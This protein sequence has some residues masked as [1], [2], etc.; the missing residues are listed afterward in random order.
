MR[1]SVRCSIFESARHGSEGFL[2]DSNRK[3]HEDVKVDTLTYEG[4]GL[5][6]LEVINKIW[7]GFQNPNWFP[8]RYSFVFIF[9]LIYIAY[10]QSAHQS[11]LTLQELL[12]GA[13][14]SV[15]ISIYLM[16]QDFDYL[17][18]YKILHVQ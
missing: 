3:Q 15:L 17:S 8:Y 18:S 2:L 14:L 12:H 10:R 4:F 13:G 5:S 6:N 9:L 11:Q 7:H 1:L 16:S